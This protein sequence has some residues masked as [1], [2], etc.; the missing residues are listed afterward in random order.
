MISKK[1]LPIE[2]LNFKSFKLTFESG[3]KEFNI[4]FLK[5]V[6][7]SYAEYIGFEMITVMLGVFQQNDWMACWVITQT[8]SSFTY[9]IGLGFSN[10]TRTI[11]NIKI[12]QGKNKESRKSAYLSLVLIAVFGII[13]TLLYSL[14]RRYIASMFIKS[15]T[16]DYV[17]LVEF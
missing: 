5:N 7:G 2:A 10:V 1:Y 15:G 12:G 3:F 8:I 9:T 13:L 16:S 17:L 6:L 14:L 11:I 4:F